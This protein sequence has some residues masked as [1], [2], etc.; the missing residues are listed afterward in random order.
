[1]IWLGSLHD[2]VVLLAVVVLQ[3][4]LR[5]ARVGLAVFLKQA[6][7]DQLLF[8]LGVG[9]FLPLSWVGLSV[10][11]DSFGLCHNSVVA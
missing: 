7:L 11:D 1:M 8:A 10:H 4:V 5:S 2:V 9:S 3:P 6:G